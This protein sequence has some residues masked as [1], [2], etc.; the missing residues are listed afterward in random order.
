MKKCFL[1]FALLLAP[2]PLLAAAPDPLPAWLTGAWA[3]K[4]G[5]EWGD[6]FWTPPRGGIMIGAARMGK[7]EKLIVWESTRIAY[8]EDGK[9]AFWAMP[10]G[11]P[12]T[13]FRMVSRG[14][15]DVVFANAAHDYPQRVRYW[16][17]GKMLKAEISMIDG[18]KAFRFDYLPMGS[19]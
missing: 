6:E 5:D 2:V 4:N 16:R 13:K 15:T 14:T 10:R 18:S 11:V 8:D 7:G 3:L 9:L 12:A 1:A 17:E 19:K